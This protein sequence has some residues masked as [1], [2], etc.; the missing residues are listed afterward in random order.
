MSAFLVISTQRELNELVDR[1]GECKPKNSQVETLIWGGYV[2]ERDNGLYFKHTSACKEQPENMKGITLAEA[3]E[4]HLAAFKKEIKYYDVPEEN[5][6]NI[7]LLANPMK[8]SDWESLQ[9]YLTAYDNMVNDNSQTQMRIFVVLM[10]YDL[11]NPAHIN[12]QTDK[13][14]FKRLLEYT[15]KGGYQKEILYIDNQSLSGAAI[16][17]EKKD[18]DIMLPRMICDFMMLISSTKHTYNIGAAIAPAHNNTHV[19][20]IGYAE[21][22]YYSKDV[23]DYLKLADEHDLYEEIVKGK[24]DDNSLDLEMSPWGLKEK[25]EALRDK[26]AEIPYNELVWKYNEENADRRIA[27]LLEELRPAIEKY[28]KE[29]DTQEIVW[30]SRDEIYA[31]YYSDNTYKRRPEQEEEDRAQYEQLLEDV[32]SNRFEHFL[33]QPPQPTPQVKEK[34]RCFFARLFRGKKM[35][36]TAAQ[37]RQPDYDEAIKMMEELAELRKEQ[38]EFKRLQGKISEY[39]RKMEA[40][41]KSIEDFKL[42]TSIHSTSVGTMIDMGALKKYQQDYR[43]KRIK[44][45]REQY[46][47]EKRKG[48]EQLLNI[49]NELSE[50]HYNKLLY[51][52]WDNPFPFIKDITSTVSNIVNLMDKL[53][54]PF[55]RYTDDS[56]TANNLKSTYIYT[57]NPKYRDL[58]KQNE[59]HMT[60]KG[61][62]TVSTHTASKICMF[63]FMPLNETAINNLADIEKQVIEEEKK[64]R[65]EE[66]RRKQEEE[67]RRKEMMAENKRRELL[68][69][70]SRMI[71]GK[72][73][74]MKRHI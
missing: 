63:Q 51:I 16:C 37:K 3:L 62:S 64:R 15:K 66:A 5:C 38:Q 74:E 23:T 47:G 25:E 31:H 20:S 65:E 73:A 21:Y 43:D 42:N 61:D 71:K 45:I 22:M 29:N 33:Y 18:L 70:L 72:I 4:N 44:A 7:F 36:T 2:E 27:T 69:K 26:Y 54:D 12:V 58:I 8:P 35:Q 17:R 24:K 56:A 46:K 14:N 13:E 11:E 1:I 68:E 52:D 53:A 49:C 30:I 10:S 34:K 6:T 57:D 60:Y 19:F 48:Y 39:E 41:N 55:V 67:E 40:A 59:Q 32:C 50:K 28:N 9:E